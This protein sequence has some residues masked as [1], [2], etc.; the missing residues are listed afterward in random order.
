MRRVMARH[1]ELN[2]FLPAVFIREVSGGRYEV[3]FERDKEGR[4]VLVNPEDI[5]F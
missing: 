5:R 1:P 3:Q 2:R 4:T